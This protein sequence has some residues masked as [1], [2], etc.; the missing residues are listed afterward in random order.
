VVSPGTV[1][2]G[3]AACTAAAISNSIIRSTLS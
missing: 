3:V 2:A 1:L